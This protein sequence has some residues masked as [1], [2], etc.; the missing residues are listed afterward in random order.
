MM[1]LARAYLMVMFPLLATG[2]YG[3]RGSLIDGR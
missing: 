3:C 1:H 2:Q